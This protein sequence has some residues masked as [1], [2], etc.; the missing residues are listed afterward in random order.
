MTNQNAK[1]KLEILIQLKSLVASLN[2]IHEDIM[3]KW[4]LLA[5]E[6]EEVKKKVLDPLKEKTET[7]HEKLERLKAEWRTIE[8]LDELGLEVALN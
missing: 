7:L 8:L 6:T 2:S 5:E 3:I 1:R 4:I